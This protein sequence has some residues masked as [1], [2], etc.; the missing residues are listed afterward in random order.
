MVSRIEED[1]AHRKRALF[2]M[3]SAAEERDR[4]KVHAVCENEKP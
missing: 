1:S 4:F 2:K 3:L